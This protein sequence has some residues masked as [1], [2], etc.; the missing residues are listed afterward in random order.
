MMTLKPVHLA[1][2]REY[3]VNGGNGVQAMLKVRPNL[4]YTQAGQNSHYILKS[5]AA[6]SYL[7]K[8]QTIMEEQSRITRSVIEQELFDVLAACKTDDDRQHILKT[9]DIMNRMSGNYNHK[10]ELE[11][12]SDGIV[13]NFIK[14][15][16]GS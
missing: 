13:I 14:P 5:K 7:Q 2:L 10:K 11:V 15:D 6:Q 1:F 3:T 9:L 4:D 8:Y 12:K 16:A